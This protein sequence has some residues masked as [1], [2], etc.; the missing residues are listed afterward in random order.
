MKTHPTPA[1]SIFIGHGSPM[2]AIQK[3]DFTDTLVKL[4]E[5]L[6]RPKA[7][8]VISAHWMTRGTW[9]LTMDQP[10][11]IHDFYGFP[12]ELFD[13]R[14]PA[15]GS[16]ETA[17]LLQSLVPNPKIGSDSADWGLDHGTWSVLKHLYPEADIPTLQLSLA[18]D[19]G[20]EYHF[21]LGQQLAQLRAHGVMILGSGNIVHNLGRIKWEQDAPAFDWAIE[22]DEW[23]K[24]R[25][26]DRDFSALTKEALKTEAGK[27][28]IPTPDHYLPLLYVLGASNSNDA[29]TFEYEGLQNA[30]ISMRSVKFETPF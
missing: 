14:Y 22:F 7:I 5:A 8:L 23:S 19:Q 28:S 27:L 18:M 1:P 11:T 10:R 25:L 17:S 6:P 29:L 21:A 20:P 3:N 12:K 26:L 30:S 9:V 15:K 16:A 24:Q 4:G 13:V 2:N